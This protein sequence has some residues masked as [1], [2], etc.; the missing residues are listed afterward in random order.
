MPIVGS[1]EAEQRHLKV[2]LID[3][4]AD[5]L[6]RVLAPRLEQ[7]GFTVYREARPGHAL[8]AIAGHQPDA[9]LL[10][11]H[12][13]GDDPRTGV[14]TGGR[15]VKQIRDAYPATAILVFTSLLG[16]FDVPQPSLAG[17]PHG[18]FVKPGFAGDKAWP[19]RLARA[20]REAVEVARSESDGSDAAEIGLHAGKTAAMRDAVAKIRQ[21]SRAQLPVLI[22]GE[23]GTGKELAARAVHRLSKRT[24]PFVAFNASGIHEDTLES[25]LFGH[26]KGAFTG[27]TAAR[28]GLF[29]LAHEGTL[30]LDEIQRMPMVLQNKLMRVVEDG[31][32]RKMGGKKDVNVDVRLVTATNCN[33]SELVEDGVMRADFAHRLAAGYRIVLPPLRDRLVDLPEL[34]VLFVREAN[35]KHAR[36]VQEILRPEVKTKLESYRWPGNL[37]ELRGTIERAVV[38]TRSNVILKDDIE[39]EMLSPSGTSRTPLTPPAAPQA[40]GPSPVELLT[41]EVMTKGDDRYDFLLAQGEAHQTDIVIEVTRRLRGELNRRVRHWDLACA[42]D[43]RILAMKDEEDWKRAYDKVRKWVHARVQLTRLDVNP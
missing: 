14:T 6:Y 18:Q 39:F 1:P 23:S 9:V 21:T 8:N 24:G 34:F 13:P 17:E 31:L 29:E 4:E 11:L 41:D 2:L 12:F 19:D 27:A 37:R 15:L 42:L 35:A 3:D 22:F 20:L 43:P 38:L 36:E 28:E 25:T 26:E 5:S 16:D 10:D 33:L 30:F 32:V 40:E 7:L